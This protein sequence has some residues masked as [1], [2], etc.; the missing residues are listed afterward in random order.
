VEEKLQ[1]SI[2]APREA[3]ASPPGSQIHSDH[4]TKQKVGRKELNINQT[5]CLSQV[6]KIKS[7]S[8]RHHSGP[9]METVAKD[10]VVS[11]TFRLAL[12]LLWS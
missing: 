7:I 6:Y 2:L 11:L 9:A 8:C 3:H 12:E 5:L 4:E 10:T 1:R